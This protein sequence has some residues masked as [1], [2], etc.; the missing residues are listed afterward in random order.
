MLLNKLGTIF[1]KGFAADGLSAGDKNRL[2]VYFL[3]AL[4]LSAWH[5]VS[6]SKDDSFNLGSYQRP[7]LFQQWFVVVSSG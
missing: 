3:V 4:A 7:L 2:G 5:I 1:S 6:F